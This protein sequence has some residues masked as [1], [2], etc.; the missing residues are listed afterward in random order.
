MASFGSDELE[1]DPARI[2]Q[3]STGS[4]IWAT[5]SEDLDCSVEERSLLSVGVLKARFEKF[6]LFSNGVVFGNFF[7]ELHSKH[8]YARAC[9]VLHTC[10]S[11]ERTA[12]H[13]VGPPIDPAKQLL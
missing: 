10:C 12:H 5:D 1:A 2:A 4:H 8:N 3:R 7:L 6:N 11:C 13:I 9:T